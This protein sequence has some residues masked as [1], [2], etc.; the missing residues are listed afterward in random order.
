MTFNETFLQK[1]Y[2]GWDK[3]EKPVFVQVGD[4]GSDNEH[5]KSVLENNTIND[6][7]NVLSDNSESDEEV[8]E[9]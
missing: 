6:N 3:I 9:C 2:G 1:P 8:K 7:Y 5:G 4:E